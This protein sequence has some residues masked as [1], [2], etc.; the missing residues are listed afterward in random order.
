MESVHKTNSLTELQR[1]QAGSHHE[2]FVNAMLGQVIAWGGGLMP[3][4]E[5]NTRTSD[6]GKIALMTG[7]NSRIGL[8]TAKQFVNGVRTYS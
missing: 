1:L 3:L 2:K 6:E 5:R 8:A 7:G 4:R